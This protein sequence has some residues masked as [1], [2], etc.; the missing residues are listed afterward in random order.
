M[1]PGFFCSGHFSL[2]FKLFSR[3]RVFPLGLNPGSWWSLSQIVHLKPSLS[4]AAF[5]QSQD[6]SS[7][8]RSAL[9]NKRGRS[10]W[11]KRSLVLLLPPLHVFLFLIF[12]SH[13]LT[14]HVFVR[15]L[16][17]SFRGFTLSLTFPPG[18]LL[19]SVFPPTSSHGIITAG[20]FR[21]SV[22]FEPS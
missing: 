13:K 15:R 18:F 6:S 2:S 21:S 7:L 3:N 1:F 22:D 11:G 8:L 19:L 5:G 14:A 12:S 9:A 10:Y 17:A 20:I 16:A 4:Y